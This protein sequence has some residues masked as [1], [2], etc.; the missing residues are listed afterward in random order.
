MK[1]KNERMNGI[2]ILAVALVGWWTMAAWGWDS[3]VVRVDT[4]GGLG[5]DIGTGVEEVGAPDG[6]GVRPWDTT[7]SADGWTALESGGEEASVL[8]LN[9]PEVAGGRLERE[10]WWDADRVRVVR[11][12]VV[13][14]AG[15]RLWLEP[16]V[17]V[18]FAEGAKIVVEEGGAL[19]AKGA[20]LVDAADDSV[21]G[22]TNM[23]GDASA[24]DG[25]EPWL[26][27]PAVGALVRVALADGAGGGYADRFYT[28]GEA[29]G[30]LP[31]PARRGAIFE[32]WFTEPNG[33]GMA[34]RPDTPVEAGTTALYALWT[35]LRVAIDPASAVVSAMG[36]TGAFDVSANAAWTAQTEASW[37]D[38]TPGD[39]TGDGRVEFAVA[40]NEGDAG[41]FATIRVQLAAADGFRDFT[42]EQPALPAVAAPVIDPADGTEF[43]GNLERVFI[44]CATKGAVVRYTLD[45]SEPNEGSAVY[46]GSFNVFDTTT[47]KARGFAEGM[48]A[49]A[50]ASAKIVR[51]RTLAEAID[52]PLWNVATDGA[53]P[54]TVVS[55]TTHDGAYAARSGVIGNNQTNRLT[56][57]VEGAGTLAFWWKVECE[58]DP[59]V[60]DNW[61]FASFSV[62]GVEAARMDGDSGWVRFEKTIAGEGA[63]TLEWTYRKD[64]GDESDTEDAMWVDEVA[65]EPTVGELAVPV[66]WMESLGLLGAGEDA[67]EVADA[68]TDGDGLTNAQEYL[69]GTDPTDPDSGFSAGLTWT[70]NQLNVTWEPELI[71]GKYRIMGRKSLLPNPEDDESEGAEDGWHDVTGIEDLKNSGY[72]F[73]RVKALGQ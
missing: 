18:K 48:R 67:A 19:V 15:A 50:V 1:M 8:V 35:P 62:D 4:R 11:D 12:D 36:G 6:S 32:G 20:L 56:A 5:G 39:G 34:A 10:T 13:V 65:W 38:V 17:V 73:F 24:P 43:E 59:S 26:D 47:V 22:D 52:Q 3:N 45:G 44:T 28:P 2:R 54:W 57:T 40:A 29:F 14:A 9:G 58:D 21:G 7:A 25:A 49:S 31:V 70:N 66:S 60:F 55:D 41:R 33:G 61:D 37:L 42:V 64:R 72:K 23:D 63:H 53:S 16:G 46:G 71:G 30:E 27:E 69:L 68:D 51:L